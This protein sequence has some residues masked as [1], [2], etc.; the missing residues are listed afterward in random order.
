[1]KTKKISLSFEREILFLKVVGPP[2]LEPGTN[3]LWADC[4]NHWAIG[5]KDLNMAVD[6]GFEPSRRLAA[7]YRFS[8]PASSATWVTHQDYRAERII[9]KRMENA[10]RF[11]GFSIKKFKIVIDRISYY[12][13]ILTLILNHSS[14]CQED[15]MTM[16]IMAQKNQVEKVWILVLLLWSG[17]SSVLQVVLERCK[18][19]KK[20]VDEGDTEIMDIIKKLPIWGVF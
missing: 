6:E 11:F 20:V 3:R 13:K 15:T 9:K 10:N 18:H 1:M 5:P 8:K 17:D 16:A 19:S 4:S 7:P 2:G 12:A 14:L